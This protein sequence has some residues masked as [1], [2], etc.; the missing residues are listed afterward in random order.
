MHFYLKMSKAYFLISVVSQSVIS[1]MKAVSSRTGGDSFRLSWELRIIF[2][3]CLQ[4]VGRKRN[5]VMWECLL[6]GRHCQEGWKLMYIENFTLC[7][8]DYEAFSCMLSQFFFTV[9]L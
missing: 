8:T 3:F 7:Q 1:S 9:M 2:G 6:L 5:A 4:W